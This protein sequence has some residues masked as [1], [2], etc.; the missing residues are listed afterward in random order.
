MEGR[1]RLPKTRSGLFHGT[2]KTSRQGTKGTA[3]D[4]AGGLPQGRK[5]NQWR[6]D[7]KSKL[8]GQPEGQGGRIFS[9]RDESGGRLKEL[10]AGAGEGVANPAC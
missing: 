8:K 6:M 3:Y 1:S 7:E 2:S 9:R 4:L 5:S 10:S